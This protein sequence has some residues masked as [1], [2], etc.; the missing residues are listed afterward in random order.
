MSRKKITTSIGIR[1]EIYE[2]LNQEAINEERSK[3]FIVEEALRQRYKLG[4]GGKEEGNV[5]R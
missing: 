2:C 5:D 3:S 4:R 1:P